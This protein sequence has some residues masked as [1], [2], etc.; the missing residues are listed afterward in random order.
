M[1]HS[2]IALVLALAAL[3][4]PQGLAQK[5]AYEKY[6]LSN[7]LTVILYPDRSL[8]QVVV[9]T[10]YR[11]GAREEPPGRSGF[12]HLF[13]HLMFMGTQ[14][15]PGN[16]F[17]V[18]METGGGANNASTSL[19]RTNYFSWGPSSL[20]PTL[21]WLDADRL[22][23]LGRTMDQAKLDKQRDIVRNEIRQ[24][25]ENTPYGRANEYLTR[26]LYPSGH[27]YHFNVYGTHEDLEAAT[28]ANVKDF[29]GT[30]YVPSNAS[31]VVAG[32]FDP[33]AVKP[34]IEKLYGSLPAGAPVK[35]R[36]AETPPL[37]GVIRDTMLDKVQLPQ[38]IIAWHSP[39]LYAEGDAEMDLVA[40]VLSS[41]KTSRLYQRLVYA[42]Q[43]AVDVSASQQAA[44]LGGVFQI[45]VTAKPG[46]DLNRLESIV[47]EELSQLVAK[48]PT[49]AELRERVNAVEASRV[50]ELQSLL[51][52]ADKLNEYEYAFGDPNGFDRDLARYRN[53][54]P[55]G[56]RAVA[57]TV[58]GAPG[59]V[60]LRVL[61][62]EPEREPS[63]RDARPADFAAGAFMPPAP[64][65]F[66][67]SSGIR[68]K[69]WSRRDLPLVA[70]SAE[71]LPGGPIAEPARAGLV[72]LM[73]SMLDEGAG[74][75]DAL[76]FSS[77]VQAL[78]ASISAG[79]SAEGV[80]VSL[81]TLSR[82][83]PE[84]VALWADAIRRPHFNPKDFERVKAI[85]LENLRQ[86]DEEPTVVAARV[87]LRQLFG[88]TNPYGRPISGTVN[89]VETLSLVDVREAHAELLSPQTATILAAGDVDAATLKRLLE[90]ALGDW[91]PTTTPKPSDR[92]ANLAAP[93][94]S[95]LRFVVVDRP[96]AVQSVIR[97]LAPAPAAAD[98]SRP[99]L[100][101]IHTILGGSFTSRLNQNLRENKG[102]TYGAGSRVVQG[103][104]NG[105]SIASSSV[106]TD[107]TGPALAEFVAEFRRLGMMGTGS[108]D[109][110]A[111]EVLKA[112]RTI[113]SDTVRSFEGASGIVAVASALTRQGLGLDAIA[114]DLATVRGL[115]AAA[116]NSASGS[117]M[118]LGKGVL[119]IVGDR[120]K[121][122]PQ[123]AERLSELGLPQPVEVDAQGEP[124]KPAR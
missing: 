2:L 56:V 74:D 63:P 107:V 26:Y 108:G 67:L 43:L 55:A 46:G 115:D 37:K 35:R 57:G 32:D 33:A 8:P 69:L 83:L 39:A 1:R 73:T 109:L 85:T 84:A 93:D 47:E 52:R 10:W 27:P 11:V 44:G 19:D 62:E 65:E 9:N 72:P 38:L 48:G 100:E 89:T 94:A 122:M 5:I 64:E 50:R 14:R 87:G 59:R 91:S 95:G 114:Q 112:Q 12:A 61:P 36:Q 118:E 90:R 60:V 105:Y 71:F 68:V 79:A 24:N 15:V 41:G 23:D 88:D 98:E 106:K 53:A 82:T 116:L 21:L 111:D 34:L 45:T 99:R 18:L 113:V 51:N 121:I 86:S 29:F 22:E 13:E 97:F 3:L 28:V 25:V 40:A 54:T 4:A 77:A 6:T 102:Y 66:T 96:D 58:L 16:Q 31:L 75:R 70:M 103:P 49:E 92:G 119:V 117:A 101:M 124:L 7:G 30:F 110:T 123:I 80:S 42:D 76:A 120:A 17:D 104:F 78:G 81:Q 20:L